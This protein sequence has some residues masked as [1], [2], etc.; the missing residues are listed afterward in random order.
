MSNVR[1]P[2]NYWDNWRVA[3]DKINDSFND[4]VNKVLWYR[5]HIESWI[6]RIW[7]TNTGIKAEWVSIDMKVESWYIWYKSESKSNWTQIIAIADLKWDKWDPWT[8]W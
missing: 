5:P 2:I 4:V 6:W 8:D 7:D 1:L 3:R